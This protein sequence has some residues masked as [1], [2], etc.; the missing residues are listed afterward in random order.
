MKCNEHL[1]LHPHSPPSPTNKKKNKKKKKKTLYIEGKGG[2]VTGYIFLIFLQFSI[3]GSCWNSLDEAILVKMR[4]VVY[5][6]VNPIF[7]YVKWRVARF[8]LHGL[9]NVL[10]HIAK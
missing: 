4:K 1:P 7:P 9:V 6:R 2:V 3:V 5:T 8:T 10:D